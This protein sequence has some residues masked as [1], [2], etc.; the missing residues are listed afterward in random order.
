MKKVIAAHAHALEDKAA[1]RTAIL[2]AA[3][4]LFAAGAGDLPTAAR[5]ASATGLAKGTI[6]LYFQTKE[7]IFAAL[8]LQKWGAVM[9]ESQ[10]LL[11]TMKG[12]RAAKVSVFLTTLVSHLSDHPE[13]LRLDALGYGVLEKNMSRDVLT[14]HKAEFTMRLERTGSMIDIALRIP[15][16]RGIELLMRTYALTRGLWQS[17]Q[18]REETFSAGVVASERLVAKPFG[19][20]LREALTEYWRG[21]LSVGPDRHTQR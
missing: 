9:E 3:D 17:Y 12:P 8:L 1:R 4:L 10:A 5:I 7:E 11:Q 20:E 21:A 6:Y 2:Q 14:T 19:V 16:G 15:E 13:L 18:H